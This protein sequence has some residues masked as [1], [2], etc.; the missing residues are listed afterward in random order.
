VNRLTAS[1]TVVGLLAVGGVAV[2]TAPSDDTIVAPF[3][4]R[5]EPGEPIASRLATV[6]V[7]DVAVARELDLSYAYD[8]DFG[9]PAPDTRSAGVWIVVSLDVTATHKSIELGNSEVRIDGVRYRAS[10]VLPDPDLPSFAFDPGVTVRGSIVFELP[11]AAVRSAAA[12]DADL[13][14]L[15]RL[16]PALDTVPTLRVD[17]RAIHVDAVAVVDEARAVDSTDGAHG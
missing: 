5:G 6:V 10:T 14:F 13:V 4:V 3:L 7:N 12:S 17:L 1:L 2:A 8:P 16:V 11:A 15:P 9:E